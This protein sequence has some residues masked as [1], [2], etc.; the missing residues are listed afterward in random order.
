MKKGSAVFQD[1]YKCF[2]LSG[3]VFSLFILFSCSAD[4]SI[5]VEGEIEDA[6]GKTIFLKEMTTTDFIIADSAEIDDDGSFSL[7]AVNTKP[8][9]YTLALSKDN[10][11]TLI[12]NPGEEISISA[13][14]K[15]LTH[16]YSVEGSKDS[17]LAKELNDKI[18]ETLSEID[19]LGKI[20]QDSIGSPNIMNIR[21]KLDSSYKII[22]N[23][24]IGF[25]KIF[26]QKNIES[27]ASLMAL[28]Q[29][30]SP[31]KSLLNSKEHYELFRMVDSVQMKVNPT[32]DAV[33][34]LHTLMSELNEEHKRQQEVDKMTAIGAIAP[35]IVLP[36]PFKDTLRLSNLKGRYV[37][38]DFWAS[39][40]NPCR[41]QN[42]E[43]FRIYWRYKY[44]GFEIFQFSLDKNR[45]AWIKAITDD[46]LTWQHV[47][48]LK[49]WNSSI[50]ALYGVQSIPSNFLLDK[51]GK[52][53][54]K[55][56]STVDLAK[57]LAE[58]FRY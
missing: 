5:K 26:I 23:E 20:Y 8:A 32:A 30:L 16:S 54:A 31:R 2:V 1:K 46:R 47:T 9:F 51:E 53:I 29:Q 10:Y 3:F 27:L 19:E 21:G 37:L 52:I 35:E 38:L 43:L 36:N 55:N 50:A 49:M 4:N 33:L 57:K 13:D 56:L 11:L 7:K 22:E 28:Y 39:W 6:H 44:A 14:G 34:S 41:Q 18:N 12:I 45:D 17:K 48:D 24:Q 25:T 42:P 58:I 40:C 15:D